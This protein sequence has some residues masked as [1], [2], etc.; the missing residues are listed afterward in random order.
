MP[1]R[2]DEAEKKPARRPPSLPEGPFRPTWESLSGYTVP[3]WYDDGKF[4][5]FIH[6]GV[7]S[8]PGV[9]QRVVP[10]EHV[11]AGD[12]G[13]RPPRR[14]LGPAGRRSATR[15]SSRC[16]KAEQFD[17]RRL[18]RALQGGGRALRGAGRRAPRRLRRCT[19]ARFTDWCAAK[20]GPKRDVVGEL[21]QAVRERG[22]VFGVSSRTAPSTGGSSTAG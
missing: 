8:V 13:V 10:A 14:D 7:Y 17:A 5:I 19:T 22:L 12:E 21:A 20:M 3:D 4:G 15:T 2:D 16:F 1:S 9:R 11:P 18:G 6:W